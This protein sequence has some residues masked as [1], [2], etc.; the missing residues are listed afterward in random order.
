M[1]TTTGPGGRVSREAHGRRVMSGREVGGTGPRGAGRYICEKWVRFPKKRV[2]RIGPTKRCD[3]ALSRKGHPTRREARQEAACSCMAVREK[4]EGCWGDLVAVRGWQGIIGRSI[5]H[6]F[7][8]VK[9]GVRGAT[10]GGTRC[11]GVRLATQADT[12]G[13]GRGGPFCA[14]QEQHLA[15]RVPG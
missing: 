14:Q 3:R 4:A 12:E 13:A 6:L 2:W 11:S 9:Y 15:T 7:Y 5:A 8:L 10:V 1:P